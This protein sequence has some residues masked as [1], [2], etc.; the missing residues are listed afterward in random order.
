[1]QFAMNRAFTADLHRSFYMVLSHLTDLVS[2]QTD[3]AAFV[4]F[5]QVVCL[6]QNKMPR[7]PPFPGKQTN[8]TDRKKTNPIENM[9]FKRCHHKLL[10]WA[11][12]LS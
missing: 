3:P 5:V 9:C 4:Q 2:V 12:N 10:L 8:R 1:M 6:L 11:C 7:P